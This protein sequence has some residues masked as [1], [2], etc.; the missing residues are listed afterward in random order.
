MGQ[1]VDNVAEIG[2]IRYFETQIEEYT[3]KGRGIYSYTA[4][5]FSRWVGSGG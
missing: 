4:V 1:G 2:S 3:N 5:I